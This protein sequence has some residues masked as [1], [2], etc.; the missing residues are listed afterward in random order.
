MESVP[1]R[2]VEKIVKGV[3]TETSRDPVALPPLYETVDPDALAIAI[4]TLDTGR[5]TFDYAGCT[6]TVR[7][8][9]RADAHCV[10]QSD[11]RQTKGSE[12]AE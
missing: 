10:V 1:G 12:H 4:D 11:D 3:A 6:V 7:T 9:E 5:V 8:G 2:I